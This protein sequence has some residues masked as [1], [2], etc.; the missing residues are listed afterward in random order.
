MIGIED[1][2]EF[3]PNSL[4]ETLG[5]GEALV[6]LARTVMPFG[7]YAGRYLVD[8]PEHYVLWF[9]NKGF[10]EGELGRRMAA[11][12]EIQAN[13]LEHLLRPLCEGGA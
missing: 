3:D 11:I 9:K 10:P 4:Y 8:L 6:S 7:R 13:G 2:P 5:D 12:C 1:C